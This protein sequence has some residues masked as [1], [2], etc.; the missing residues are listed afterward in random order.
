M[1][2]HAEA[3]LED[4]R[5]FRFGPFLLETKARQLS[6]NGLRVK[7]RGQP[8][9]ILEA[10]VFRA[11][12]VVTREELRQKLWA[13]DVFVDFDR[14]L[15]TAVRSLRQ[16]LRD[17]SVS[18]RYIE[19]IPRVGYRFIAAIE[20]SI[21]TAV[22]VDTQSAAVADEPRKVED[23]SSIPEEPAL[24]EGAGSQS[25]DRGSM[26]TTGVALGANKHEV[27]RYVCGALSAV[28]A[29][30]LLKTI[31]PYLQWHYP[32]HTM[33]LA[34]ALSS[35]KWNIGPSLVTLVT[36]GLG[37][38]YWFLPPYGSFQIED[39]SQA[40]GLLGFVLLGMAMTYIVA[41]HSSGVALGQKLRG[42]LR[43]SKP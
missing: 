28:A 31:N 3:P 18:P 23:L 5:E 17:S 27:T 32:Y 25:L 15:N 41:A 33:W 38:W 34:V 40:Y 43:L 21:T 9:L 10:L 2:G 37:V 14:C 42:R 20:P 30:L 1:A 22:R 6:R 8:Y 39:P 12:E 35:R 4:R 19:T 11:G 26:V 36:G 24:G 13:G 16:T 7:L 29:L